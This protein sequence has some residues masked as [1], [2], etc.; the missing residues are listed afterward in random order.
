MGKGEHEGFSTILHVPVK[1]LAEQSTSN[2]SWIGPDRNKISTR[3]NKRWCGRGFQT[4]YFH[5]DLCMCLCKFNS[6]C[7]PLSVPVPTMCMWHCCPFLCFTTGYDFISGKAPGS[8][9]G[10]GAAPSARGRR[11]ALLCTPLLS[12][13][14]LRHWT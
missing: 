6:P 3:S 10:R 9:K 4:P 11:L 13:S 8:R 7:Y 1:D 5:Q 2:S 12:R 14:T